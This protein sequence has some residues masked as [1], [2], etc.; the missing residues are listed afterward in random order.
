MAKETVKS[1]V[2]QRVTKLVLPVAAKLAEGAVAALDAADRLVEKQLKKRE[3]PAKKDGAGTP[4]REGAAPKR[5]SRV[6]A[7]V[8]ARP[9][10][11]KKAVAKVAKK[12]VPRSPG[13]LKP[14]RGQKHR[15][16]R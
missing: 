5:A 9:V 16:H 13:G 12:E 11:A 3:A 6:T 8:R 4:M 7:K 15:H 14:K 2:K 10:A 1:K